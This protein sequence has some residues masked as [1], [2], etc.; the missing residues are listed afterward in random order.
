MLELSSITTNFH[1]FSVSGLLLNGSTF[2]TGGSFEFYT[3]GTTWGT[4]GTNASG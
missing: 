1:T 2:A 4:G 3:G